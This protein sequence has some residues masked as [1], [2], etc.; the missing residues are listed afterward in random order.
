[1]DEEQTGEAAAADEERTSRD[2]VPARGA[3]RRAALRIRRGTG[4]L[5][6][7]SQVGR[8]RPGNARTRR[9]G[10]YASLHPSGG[11]SPYAGGGDVARVVGEVLRLTAERPLDAVRQV[12]VAPVEYLLEEVDEE[13]D[14]FARNPL[15]VE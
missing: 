8:A 7:R 5:G 2:R 14:P 10:P 13:L 12:G 15:L 1:L 3:P 4:R 6:E 11:R 9:I